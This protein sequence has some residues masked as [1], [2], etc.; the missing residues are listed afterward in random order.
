[1][2][3]SCSDGFGRFAVMQK[4]V[5]QELPVYATMLGALLYFFRS[6]SFPFAA[7]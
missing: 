5:G 3:A 7:S 6:A 4:V 1:M 2:F